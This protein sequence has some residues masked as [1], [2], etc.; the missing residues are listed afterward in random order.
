MYKVLVCGAR[1]Y[2]DFYTQAEAED[3]IISCLLS[4]PEPPDKGDV[5]FISGMARGADHIPLRM[6]E[7]DREWGDIEKYYAEWDRYGKSAGPR[8]N[9]RML[10][11]GKPDMVIAFPTPTSKGTWHMVRIARESGVTT[12]IYEGQEE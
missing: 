7:E 2:Y 3:F 5:T 8:R 12:F 11:E 10:D 1:D 6:I 4:L 9:K